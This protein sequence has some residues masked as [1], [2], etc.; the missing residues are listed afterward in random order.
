M[1]AAKLKDPQLEYELQELYILSK[2]WT[3]DVCF[4]EDEIRF[5]KNVLHKY[6]DATLSN[7]QLSEVEAVKRALINLEFDIPCLKGEIKEFLKFIEPMIKRSET[8]IGINLLDKY[9]KLQAEIEALFAAVKIVKKSL[10][11]FTEDLMKK[12]C[13]LFIDQL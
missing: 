10:F 1:K 13:T 2:H 12:E 11:S 4:A 5:L 9:T 6:W 3:S 8:E 7:E